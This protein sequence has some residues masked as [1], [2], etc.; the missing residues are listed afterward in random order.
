LTSSASRA[1]APAEL[2]AAWPRE[3]LTHALCV[4]DE[5]DSTQRLARTL[6]DR[7]LEDDDQP[8]PMLV[9]SLAQSAGR[10]RRGR[11][12]SS[13]NGLGVWA[14][15]LVEV[16]PA[17]LPAVPLRAGAALARSLARWLE[18][19]RLK[20][21]NDLIFAGRKLGGLLVDSVRRGDDGTWAL[22]GFGVNVDHRSAELP[23]H[24]ATS[25]RL[26]LA[27]APPP[28]LPEV[29]ATLAL[30][31]SR[32]LARPDSQWLARYRRL[33]LHAAGDR[34]ECDLDGERVAGEFIAVDEQ[35]SLRLRVGDGER[36]ISSGDVFS[37]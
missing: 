27:P 33:S 28:P 23:H 5:I 14:T 19:V 24:S 12:W 2:A 37:W 34:I 20:W 25:L 7:Q 1:L 11:A 17:E 9:A 15:L 8:L 6:L 21:P 31:L 10:G 26:A 30:D 32:E 3:M 22:V 29:L 36:T 4:Y 18:G 16:P 35:G 13:A